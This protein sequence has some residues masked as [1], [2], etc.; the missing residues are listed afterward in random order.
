MN[1]IRVMISA[2]FCLIGATTLAQQ[3]QTIFGDKGI[4]GSTGYGAAGNKFTSINGH[5][6]NMPE[7]YG[8]W[9]VNHRFMIGLEMAA[10]TNRIPVPAANQ[11]VPDPDRCY[12]YGQFGLM[13]E[14]VFASKKSF[15]VAVNLM[16]GSG[17]MLQYYR[18]NKYDWHYDSEVYDEN[19]FFVMEPGVQL[20]V[21]LLQWLRFSPGISYRRAFGSSSKGLTDDDISSLSGNLTLKFGRF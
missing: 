13:T 6:A 21:N 18:G 12:Q 16:T 11:I 8:G 4:H 5:Y 9:F 19:F 7:I 17:F 1:P 2:V 10:T 20:E 14:Y 15:H 3:N